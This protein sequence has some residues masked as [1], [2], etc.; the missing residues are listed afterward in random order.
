MVRPYNVELTD[1]AKMIGKSPCFGAMED[2]ADLNDIESS[3]ENSGLI[4]EPLREF[5]VMGVDESDSSLLLCGTG[6]AQ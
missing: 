1:S 4:T 2:V 6:G 5:N 3:L